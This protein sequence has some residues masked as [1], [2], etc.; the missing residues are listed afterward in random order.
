MSREALQLKSKQGAN[1]DIPG[2][3]Y[4]QPCPSAAV[5]ISTGT[6]TNSGS[7]LIGAYQLGQL[8]TST[9]PWGGD[10]AVTFSSSNGLLGTTATAGPFITT[11]NYM[12]YPVKIA[13][14]AGAVAPT[15][16]I[17]GQTYYYKWVSATTG[18]FS[19]T[20]GGAAIAYTDAGSGTMYLQAATLYWGSP[21]VPAG[22]LQAADTLNFSTAGSF[23]QSGSMYRIEIIGSHTA[24]T[25]STAT[26]TAGLVTSAGATS[27]TS[28]IASAA[29]AQV[30]VGPFP[31][32]ITADIIIQQYGAAAI[33]SPYA[34]S[35]IRSMMEVQIYTAAS[36]INTTAAAW[37]WAAPATA[38]VVAL[39][40][41]VPVGFD[42]RVLDGTPN[43]GN[44]WETLGVR[45]WAYN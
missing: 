42:V 38:R 43:I 2:L 23:P 4:N 33:S 13:L 31:F 3:F 39:D 25:T 34:Q 20:P 44:Y 28:L 26:F 17:P 21:F 37:S 30:A 45:M 6:V 40:T 22:F 11:L 19:L 15:G 10:A 7:S 16:L 5:G 29:L 12:D 9:L 24:A 1:L 32:K 8:T 14:A 41:T 27:F 35:I 18:N 36:G